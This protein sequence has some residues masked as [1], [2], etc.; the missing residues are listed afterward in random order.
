MRKLTKLKLEL[1]LRGQTQRELAERSGLNESVIS[2]I[3]NGR[4]LP[5][6]IQR[7]RIAD[8]LQKPEKEVFS[9]LG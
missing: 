7:A 6:S 9:E 2:L 3:L 4:Y 8:A 5:D 1:W